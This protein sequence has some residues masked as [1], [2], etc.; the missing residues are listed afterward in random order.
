MTF[1]ELLLRSLK[2]RE[3][4][5]QLMQGAVDRRRSIPD[6]IFLT[7]KVP[8]PNRQAQK[9]II[10]IHRA[11]EKKKSQIKGLARNIQEEISTL[12]E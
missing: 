4:Y 10:A 8:L 6:D 2:M 1:L 5:K 3:V 9:R 7:I 12:W 11:M